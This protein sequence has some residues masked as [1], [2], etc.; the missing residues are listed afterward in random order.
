MSLQQGI[1]A[2]LYFI[3]YLLTFTKVPIHMFLLRAVL[4]Q[5]AASLK[6][7]VFF[8]PCMVSL[9]RNFIKVYVKVHATLE[10]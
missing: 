3:L 1:N 2:N 10:K 8:F 7:I 9:S 5:K 4:P 6:V